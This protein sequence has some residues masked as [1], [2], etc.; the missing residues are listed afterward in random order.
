MLK[1]QIKQEDA[2]I[3]STEPFISKLVFWLNGN[4]NDQSNYESSHFPQDSQP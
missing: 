3:K 4:Q 2:L 1:K